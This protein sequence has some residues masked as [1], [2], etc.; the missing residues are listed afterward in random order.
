MFNKQ[1]ICGHS[2]IVSDSQ[3]LWNWVEDHLSVYFPSLGI[4]NTVIY[5]LCLGH[6]SN[7]TNTRQAPQHLPYS[8]YGMPAHESNS[9]LISWQCGMWVLSQS[10]GTKDLE[11][12]PE[13]DE[14]ITLNEFIIPTSSLRTRRHSFPPKYDSSYISWKFMILAKIIPAFITFSEYL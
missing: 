10:G 9:W 11:L 5:L 6:I 3:Q 4:N 7:K 8:S 1:N 2:D 13:E 14:N 12:M